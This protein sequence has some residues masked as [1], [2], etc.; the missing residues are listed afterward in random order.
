MYLV[1]EE[2]HDQEERRSSQVGVSAGWVSCGTYLVQG[3]T[4][5]K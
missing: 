3:E 2:E 1:G 4:W 5:R